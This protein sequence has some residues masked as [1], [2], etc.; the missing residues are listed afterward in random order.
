MKNGLRVLRGYANS[1]ILAFASQKDSKKYQREENKEHLEAIENF[2]EK[3]RPSAKYLPE[4]TLV[5][6]GYE[7]LEKIK[8]SGKLND[9][10]QGELDN[11]EYYK[12]TVNINQLFRVDGNHR[13]EALKT[14][15]YYIPYS[16]IIWEDDKINPDDEAFLFYFLNAKA[17][18]LTTEENLKGLVNATTWEDYELIEAN[19]YIPHLKFLKEQ[20]G[21]NPLLNTIFC[22][23]EPIKLI[24]ELLENIDA[25]IDIN[26]FK[27]TVICMGQ[28]LIKNLW[29]SLLQFKFYCQLLFYV[30]YKTK[31]LE[32]AIDT[33][34][35]LESWVA[36]YNF[37]NTTFD[38]P[39]LLY[40]N[41]VKTNNLNPINIFVAMRY[42]EININNFTEWIETAIKNIEETKP[43]YKGRLYL[44]KIMTHRG[45]NIDLIDDIMQKIKECS[46]FIADI[47]PF[48][49]VEGVICDAN[50]NVMYEL[51]IA[52]KLKKP[53]VLMREGSI[54]PSV[55][56]DIQEKYRNLYNKSDS[57]GTR[58]IL[59]NAISNILEDFY[60]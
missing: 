7:N 45:Y 57:Q 32:H 9:A 36:K 2:I 14:G 34:N 51:G 6:R 60:S 16:I 49:N 10:Q 58:E 11:L 47:S 55:P 23:N 40:N 26:E 39:I 1:S 25:N 50:P 54:F 37:D 59:Q 24:A 28:L 5:A 46:I 15:N 8:L 33:L 30:A 17:R 22:N 31:S 48:K 19:K 3:I 41:A 27:Q 20:F 44:N 38:D 29:P 42:D 53:I 52:Y 12:L 56:S 21:K 43:K 35:N 4:V 13:L 18:K